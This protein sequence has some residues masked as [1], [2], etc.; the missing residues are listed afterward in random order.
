MKS[1]QGAPPVSA[2]KQ[3]FPIV[4]IGASA[5]GLKALQEFLLHLPADLGMAYVLIP[6]LAPHHESLMPQL[7]KKVSTMSILEVVEGIQVQ[8]N[9]VYIVTPNT[10]LS[11]SDGKL[12]T[13]KPRVG[14]PVQECIDSF[15]VSLAEAAGEKAIG[16]I[17]SGTASDGSVGIKAVK[18][19]GGITFA[20]DETAEFSGMPQAAIGTGAVDFVFPPR[21]IA[22]ELARI[23]KHPYLAQRDTIAEDEELPGADRAELAK[24]LHHL[25]RRT[26]VEFVHYK[27]GTVRRRIARRMAL[28]RFATLQEY[29]SYLEDNPHEARILHDDILIHVTSFFR[30]PECFEALKAK[31]FPELLKNRSPKSPVRM[32]VAGCSTGEEVYSLAMAFLEFLDAE[33]LGCEVQIFASDVSQGS[34]TRARTGLYE[35]SI[36]G[37]VS[38]DRLKRFFVHADGGRFLINKR[39]RDLC[40]FAKQDVTRDP[41]F[42]KIDLISCRNVLIYLGKSLQNRVIPLFHYALNPAGFLM[43]GSSETVEGFPESFHALDKQHRIYQKIPGSQALALQLSQRRSWTEDGGEPKEER[44]VAFDLA[45]EVE[46]AIVKEFAPAGIVV[47]KAG[48]ILEFRGE[49]SPLLRP[50]PGS[51]TPALDK[52]VHPDLLPAIHGALREAAEKGVSVRRERLSFRLQESE[53]GVAVAVVPLAGPSGE[54]YFLIFFSELREGAKT[55]VEPDKAALLDA[56]KRKLVEEILSLRQAHAPCQEYQKSVVEKAEASIEELRTANEEVLSAN[57]E[58]QSSTEELETAKEEL[59]SS[60]EELMT[61]NDELKG[62]NLELG[63]VNSDLS[64]VLASVQVPIAIVD[65]N[66][67]LRR[68]T[69]TAEKLLNIGTGDVKR[70]VTDFRPSIELPNLE[71]LLR[72]SIENLSTIEREVQD[73]EGRWYT[74]RI[75]PY[76]T[77]D[78]KIDGAVLLFLD[79]DAT[80]KAAI[81]SDVARVFSD[82]VVD[83]VRH[84]ILV[85]DAGLRVRRA[86]APFYSE[87]QV[88]PEDTENRLV[89]ELQEGGWEIPRLRA[90]LEEILPKNTRFDNFEVEHEFPRIGK[91]TML[92]YGRRIQFEHTRDPMILLCMEDVTQR[93]KAEAEI[94]K[95]NST[96]ETRVTERTAQLAHSRGEMEAFTYT[97]AHDLRAPLRAMHGLSQVVIE[98]YTG[99]PLDPAGVEQLVRIMDASRRMDA[100]IQDLLAYSQLAREELRLEAINLGPFVEGVLRDL[101]PQTDPLGAEIVVKGPLPTVEAHRTTLLQALTNILTNAIKFTAPGVKPRIC[102]RAE[103]LENRHLVWVED[104]GIGIAPEFHARVFKVFERLHKAE[105]YPGTGIGLAIAARAIERMGGRIGVESELGRGS[106]FWIEFPKTSVEKSK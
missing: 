86:N 82:A 21:G 25:E 80:K 57:E 42:S 98:E 30:D 75:R 37:E 59:Q 67:H 33:S 39:V 5:G 17:L 23:A 13:I 71:G 95:L 51:P 11:L 47:N 38:P 62:R 84:P 15:L 19:G 74:L 7:L 68:V 96:L 87:F 22:E 73:R 20:Q 16:I 41:P 58:L 72:T 10:T 27:P 85:L 61:L 48:Q 79:I 64:N 40:L 54:A 77:V 93:R 49:M 55:R 99:R 43:L 1:G 26:G 63:E 105:E 34:I 44:P 14:G 76:R 88:A 78:H 9:H 36:A 24:L 12:H 35:G 8:P 102:I 89:Y 103:T 3:L 29:G 6:H 100:L 50:A 4:G 70:K 31:V 101:A 28:K 94:R 104:N 60:N 83:T 69:P 92:L 45:R 32:W 46:R 97:V 90:L 81:E 18:A 56:D 91:K 106:R 2:R 66:L 52:M 65:I 53:W